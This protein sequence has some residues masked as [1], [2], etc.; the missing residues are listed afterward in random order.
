MNVP[1][2][3]EK[4]KCPD[5]PGAELKFKAWAELNVDIDTAAGVTVIVSEFMKEAAKYN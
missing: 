1:L 4:L 2:F 3:D 5:W